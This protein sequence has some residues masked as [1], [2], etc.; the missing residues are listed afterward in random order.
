VSQLIPHHP[1][2]SGSV[3]LIRDDLRYSK[4]CGPNP[5][6]ETQVELLPRPLKNQCLS[7]QQ[8]TVSVR[9]T[10]YEDS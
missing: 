9:I 8:I 2:I 10:P 1:K 6:V 5:M 4:F 3:E 7:D